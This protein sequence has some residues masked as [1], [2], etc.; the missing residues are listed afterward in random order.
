MAHRIPDHGTVLDIGGGNMSSNILDDLRRVFAMAAL[1]GQPPPTMPDELLYDDKGLAIWADI[2]FTPEFYQ[3]RDEIT[4]FKKNSVEIANYI[5]E[6]A[7]M[8][9][10]GAGDMRKVNFLLDQLTRLGREATYLAL[11]ISSRSLTT[12]LDL[13]APE[14]AGGSVH[15]AGLWGDFKAGIDFCVA[16]PSSS[17]RMFLSLGS[18]LFNDPW[19]KAVDSLREWAAL[20]RRDDL[21]LAG[22]DGHDVT[23]AKVWD[24]YHTHPALFQDFFCNGLEH[25]NGLLGERVFKAEDWDICA[26]IEEDEGRHRFFLKAKQDIAVTAAARGSA[27]DG[28]QII[29][30]GTEL[31]WFD[32]HKRPEWMVTKMCAEAGLEVIRSWAIDGSDMRQYL[33]RRDH[34]A[35][36]SSD[37]PLIPPTS[38]ERSCSAEVRGKKYGQGSGFR[39]HV[40]QHISGRGEAMGNRKLTHL[41]HTQWVKGG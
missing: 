38:A 39:S 25:A 27:E 32:A 40:S 29:G 14:H 7:I 23:S 34:S 20:M 28:I 9:D 17:P 35:E 19:H 6:G 13:L 3:T 11:D 22:M 16:L 4:L 41:Q 12:N 2:I 5:P 1:S 37:R 36:V 24:A 18:V 8:V 26:G 10:L 33:I 30:R 31:D 21:I 15:M